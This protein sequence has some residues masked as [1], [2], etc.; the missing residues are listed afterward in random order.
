MTDEKWTIDQARGVYGVGQG[1][2]EFHFL[3]ID[4]KGRLCLKIGGKTISFLEILEQLHASSGYMYQQDYGQVP[5]VTL[6]IPQLIEHQIQKLKSSF[7][8][9]FN[10][11]EYGGEFAP[12]YPIKVNQ[13]AYTIRTVL[14]YGG[15]KYGLEAGTL[16]ELAIC[17]EM[18]KDR[19]EQSTIVCNGVKDIE[20]LTLIDK[21]LLKGYNIIVSIESFRELETLLSVISDPSLVKIALRMKPYFSVSG[22]WAKSSGRDSKFG[23]SIDELSNVLDFLLENNQTSLVTTIHSHIGSQITTLGDF[24]TCAIYMTKIYREI[25]DLGFSNL[26][27]INFGGGLAID[28]QGFKSNDCKDS[29]EV[30]AENLVRSVLAEVGSHPHPNI[31]V[32]A[33]RAVTALASMVAVQILETREIFP[34]GP[35]QDDI[36][37]DFLYWKQRILSINSIADFNDVWIEF[38]SKR[39]STKVG[40]DSIRQMEL[41]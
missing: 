13:H 35:L 21:K 20:Y 18:L 17:L 9:F 33:G 23:L 6:R 22:H 19:K 24:K 4:K 37:E 34:L 36:L 1:F 32:E 29:F 38:E 16:S 10:Q 40:I 14:G 27:C 25:R 41:L 3:D 28:Y 26:T 7:Q 15:E 11:L 5:S 39:L 30:Y 31:M 2:R 12:V 8:K